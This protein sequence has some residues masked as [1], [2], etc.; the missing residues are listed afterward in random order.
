M[1]TIYENHGHRTLTDDICNMYDIDKNTVHVNDLYMLTKNSLGDNVSDPTRRYQASYVLSVNLVWSVLF[2]TFLMGIMSLV[3]S[4]LPSIA[5][6]VFL[7]LIG[8]IAMTITASFHGTARIQPKYINS[9]ATDY[10]IQCT[11]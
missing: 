5:P 6:L 2:W 3:M 7:L 11:E 4:N 10:F 1:T 9:L 8:G